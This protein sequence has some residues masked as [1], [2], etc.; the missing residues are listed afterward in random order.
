[1]PDSN[2]TDAGAD[3]LMPDV[4][5]RLAELVRIPSVAFPGFDPDPVH[6]MGEAVVRLFKDVGAFDARLLDVPGGYPCVYADLPGP[7]GSPTVLLYAHYDVQP[8]PRSQG[9]TSE[10]F[11]PVTKEDGRIYGRGAADDKSGLVIHYATL[12]LLGENRPCRVKLLVEGEEETISHLEAFVE[13]NPEL[14]ACD[15]AVIADIGGQEAGRPGLTT[16]LRGDVACTITVRTLA[17]PVHSGMFGGAAPDA[18]TAMIRIL[19]SLHDE[20]GDTVIDGVDSGSWDG[21]AMDE[22]VYRDG[23]SILPGVEF[24]GTGSLADRIWMRPSVTVLGMDLPGTAEASNVLLPEVTAKLS[25][26]IIPGSDGDA[27]LE[28]LMAHLRR[29]RPWNCEVEVEK[30]KVGQAF[31][32]DAEHPAIRAAT[33]ALD[34]AY[35]RPAELIGSGASI[36]LVSSLRS[37]SPGAAIVLWGAEDTKQ[38]RIHASDESVDPAEIRRMIDAQVGFIRRFAGAEE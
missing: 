25:M 13:A 17:N 8:A 15:A 7:D 18:M 35:D 6:R 22:D 38:S 36:P 3:N 32:V 34:D 23:S 33:D 24:L 30:V 28:A 20:N 4:L 16:A 11:E 2:R 37:V 21:A 29:Q 1:M 19:D 31:R 26:R 12:S 27:Q 14:F 5:E 9:W 10:P